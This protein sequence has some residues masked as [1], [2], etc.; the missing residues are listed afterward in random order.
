MDKRGR[1]KKFLYIVGILTTTSLFI[2]LLVGYQL[3]WTG[4]SGYNEVTVST[5][6]SSPQVITKTEKYQPGKTL[7]DW[8][9][10]LIIPTMLATGGF[11]F[12]RAERKSADLTIEKREKVDK[13]IASEIARDNILEEYFDRISSLILEQDLVTHEKNDPVANIARTRTLTSLQRLGSDG[14]RKGNIL[15]FI[16]NARLI[17]TYHEIIVL[18]QANLEGAD[19]RRANL[20]GANLAHANLTGANLT[21]A[22]F[23]DANLTGA[24]LADAI[25]SSANLT[26]A[27]LFQA[28]LTGANLEKTCLLETNLQEADLVRSNLADSDLTGA[29][30]TRAKMLGVRLRGANLNR[31]NLNS[32]VVTEEE[33]NKVSSYTGTTMPSGSRT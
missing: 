26:R 23:V 20:A 32:A 8:F 25:L 4:F 1:K 17:S 13:E 21:G 15:L 31:A 11:L 24:N 6:N 5:N 12:T 29:N 14:K 2:L 9:S 3:T 22:D 19:L 16:Y 10:L 33:L 7:W 27:K 30:L 18:S 28:T